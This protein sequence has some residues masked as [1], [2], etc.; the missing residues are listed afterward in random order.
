[1]KK[2]AG[3]WVSAISKHLVA[4]LIVLVA[5]TAAGAARVAAQPTT[6]EPNQPSAAT[7]AQSGTP[8]P[9]GALP[10]QSGGP[11][12]P[13][14][15]STAPTPGAAAPAIPPTSTPDLAAVLTP[16]AGDTPAVKQFKESGKNP[17][18]QDPKA[19]AEGFKLARASA[20]THCHGESLGGLI[21]PSL[22]NG[23]WRHDRTRARRP[24]RQGSLE[25]RSLRRRPQAREASGNEPQWRQP[26]WRESLRHRADRRGTPRRR[27]ERRQSRHRAPRRR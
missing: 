13:P 16:K 1:M 22:T 12:T 2:S 27:S 19:I 9:G 25:P 24:L 26:C 7:P 10:S 15:P 23:N 11:A 20:C 6:T 14:T 21:G 17:Y 18:Y 8:Q 4:P 5:I 3:P